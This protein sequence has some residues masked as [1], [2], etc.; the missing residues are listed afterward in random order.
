MPPKTNNVWRN[1]APADSV[2][3]LTLPSGQTCSARRIGIESL[4]ATGLLGEAD[5]LTAYVDQK[6]IK[7]VNGK[8]PE[9][10]VSSAMKDP[11]TLQQIVLLVDRI[12]PFIVADPTVRSHVEDIDGG[13]TRN[14]PEAERDTEAVYT[15]QIPLEDKMFL[16][17]FAVGGTR[18]ADRFLGQSADA[19]AGV[20]DVTDVPRTS[21]DRPRPRRKRAPRR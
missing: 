7:R 10:D 6:H 11:K 2:E 13:G 17:N 21:S 12:T 3:F 15:D 19:V 16:F 20:A 18:S 8:E 1:T 9:V 14:I 4:L 5:S